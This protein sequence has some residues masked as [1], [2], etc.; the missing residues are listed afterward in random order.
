MMLCCGKIVFTI[1]RI[2]INT[3]QKYQTTALSVPYLRYCLM[4]SNIVLWFLETFLCSSANTSS[5]YSGRTTT[6]CLAPDRIM[7][8]LLPRGPPL[9][10]LA[11]RCINHVKLGRKPCPAFEHLLL[12]RSK[13]SSPSVLVVEACLVK[14]LVSAVCR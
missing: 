6:Y 8:P 14:C 9:L 5:E 12:N 3:E 1:G 10:C 4:W 7:L 2:P 13:R 11:L